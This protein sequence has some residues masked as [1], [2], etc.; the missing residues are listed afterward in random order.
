MAVHSLTVT[1]WVVGC[2]GGGPARA[3][4][5]GVCGGRGASEGTAGGAATVAGA[6]GKPAEGVCHL[7]VIFIL[8]IALHLL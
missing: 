6:G 2:S 5:A 8:Y 3:P 4:A 7:W 1:C